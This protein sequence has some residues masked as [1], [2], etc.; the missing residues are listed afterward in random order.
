MVL[1]IT[2]TTSDVHVIYSPTQ[3]DGCFKT[4]LYVK[5]AIANFI[6]YPYTC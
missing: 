2:A 6:T 1:K 5:S 4:S 3:L